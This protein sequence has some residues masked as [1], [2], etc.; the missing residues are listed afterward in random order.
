MILMRQKND[1]FER[2]PFQIGFFIVIQTITFWIQRM[3][4]LFSQRKEN[5]ATSA[6][7]LEATKSFKALRVYLIDSYD[8]KHQTEWLIFVF[9]LLQWFET[10]QTKIDLKKSTLVQEKWDLLKNELK[11]STRKAFFNTN[12]YWPGL[13]DYSFHWNYSNKWTMENIS[14]LSW[15]TPFVFI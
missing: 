8:C 1:K 5:S 9:I 10:V 15:W 3:I 11:I 13:L 2:K 12:K 4:Y 14:S 6:P 7:P